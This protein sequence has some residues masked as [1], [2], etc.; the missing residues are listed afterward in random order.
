MY[1]YSFYAQETSFLLVM[2]KITEILF[3]NMLRQVLCGAC[4]STFFFSYLHVSKLET[5]TLLG[6]YPLLLM[7]FEFHNF[8]YNIIFASYDFQI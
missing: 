1:Q 2:K 6:I 5:K 7:R 8:T 4:V 3:T